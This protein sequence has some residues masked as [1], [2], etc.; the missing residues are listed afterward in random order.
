MRI[1]LG[2]FLAIALITSAA[3][4]SANCTTEPTATVE[5]PVRTIYIVNDM[6]QPECLFSI[7]IYEES[8]GEPGLQRCHDPIDEEGCCGGHPDTILF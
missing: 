7:W 2:I 3:N 1:F 4:A 6:C 8:N 5:T